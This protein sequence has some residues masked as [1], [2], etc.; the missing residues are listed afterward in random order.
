MPLLQ[1]RTQDMQTHSAAHASK[2]TRRVIASRQPQTTVWKRKSQGNEMRE[3]EEE[4]KKTDTS[5]LML[6]DVCVSNLP[7]SH[8][9][10][11]SVQIFIILKETMKRML[12]S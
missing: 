10:F 6:Q 3:M 8:P 12:L 7:P 9:P 2:K 5:A 11:T 4:Q 1:D